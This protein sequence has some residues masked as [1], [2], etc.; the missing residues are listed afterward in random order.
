MTQLSSKV[1]IQAAVAIYTLSF[2]V[3][4]AETLLKLSF[5]KA[6][7]SAGACGGGRN[8][9][10]PPVRGPLSNKKAFEPKHPLRK[11][12][13]RFCGIQ[14]VAGGRCGLGWAAGAQHKRS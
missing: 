11:S 3:I 10:A 8:P 4:R 14:K 6:G 7:A 5:T 2:C 13:E 12:L 9:K 1:S